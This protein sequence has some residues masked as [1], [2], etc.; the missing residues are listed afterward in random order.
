MKLSKGL[1]G[2]P[3]QGNVSRF[4]QAHLQVICFGKDIHR[5]ECA[6]QAA[7]GGGDIAHVGLRLWTNIWPLL[8]NSL[9][10]GDHALLFVVLLYDVIQ[11]SGKHEGTTHNKTTQNAT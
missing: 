9:W 5:E 3:A 1:A 7:H 10:A 6:S 2:L 4:L 11:Y 8:P